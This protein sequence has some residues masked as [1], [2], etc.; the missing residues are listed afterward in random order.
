MSMEWTERQILETLRLIDESEVD[1][2]EIETEHFRLHV[3]KSAAPEAPAPRSAP[4]PAARE[5]AGSEVSAGTAPGA[6]RPAAR[7]REVPAGA[8]A[9]RAPVMGTF[10]RAPAPHLPPFVEVGSRVRPEDPVGLIEV[11][12]LFNTIR[13]GVAGRIVRIL[14]QN[15]AAVEQDE[16]LMVIEPS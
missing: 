16:I 13:A 4:A 6:G 7:E 15:G 12:K 2:V 8:V 9:V 11:M 1:E 14:V 10:Y 5:R 3:R